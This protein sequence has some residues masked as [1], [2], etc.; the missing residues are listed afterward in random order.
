MKNLLTFC[1]E[2]TAEA[3][4]LRKYAIKI[5]SEILKMSMQLSLWQSKVLFPILKQLIPIKISHTIFIKIHSLK[6]SM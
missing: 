6:S 5:S 1:V 2:N 3:Q 4:I